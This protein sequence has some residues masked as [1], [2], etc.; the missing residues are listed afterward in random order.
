[1]QLLHAEDELYLAAASGCCMGIM[2]H[3]LRGKNVKMFEA[4]RAIKWQ[5]IAPPFE[6]SK[7]P[8]IHSE[9]ILYD[10]HY[11]APGSFWDKR[12][13][14]KTIR[15]GAPAITARGLS[16]PKVENENIIE[17][18]EHP[19]LFASLNPN[20]A[21]SIASLGR[22]NPERGYYTPKVTISLEVPS[23]KR[24]FGIFGEFE[25]LILH[26][27]K[28]ELITRIWAQDLGKDSAEDITSRVKIEKNRIVI[29]GEL[30]HSLGTSANPPDDP[31]E[32]GIVLKIE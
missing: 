7:Y 1:M 24:F 26:S 21:I 28:S 30:I 4:V 32:P 8:V 10:S 22:T 29:L 11:F 20:G 9:E 19:Y 12:V 3:P 2:R 5:R 15:Q 13:I 18:D 6:A 27:N 14:N 17:L 16:L 31:S 25:S 23:F